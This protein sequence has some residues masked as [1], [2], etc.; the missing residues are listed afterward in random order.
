MIS[1]HP[2]LKI[3]G[4]FASDVLR[5]NVL[6]SEPIRRGDRVKE[7]HNHLLL[8]SP[9]SADGGVDLSS[10]DDPSIES[11]ANFPIASLGFFFFGVC[12]A[13]APASARSSSDD[14]LEAR[15]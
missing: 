15:E 14:E 12:W 3:Q 1:Y 7:L 11:G 13:S 2:I 8:P 9:I 6:I 4:N 10:T 5:Q